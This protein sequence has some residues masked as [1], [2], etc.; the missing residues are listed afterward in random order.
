MAGIIDR[1]FSRRS[2]VHECQVELFVL[3]AKELIEA[4]TRRPQTSLAD[5]FELPEYRRFIVGAYAAGFVCTDLAPMD[6]FEEMNTRPREHLF[7]IGFNKLRHWVHTLL[8]AERWADGYSSPIREAIAGGVLG[9]VVGR[10][11]SD[12]SL[13]EEDVGSLICDE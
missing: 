6:D 10:L 3:L 4:Q 11:E 8:R 12:R 1:P 2:A 13:R 7:G 9:I 5:W